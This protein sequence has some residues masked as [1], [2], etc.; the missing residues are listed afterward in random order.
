MIHVLL[1][2]KQEYALDVAHTVELFHGRGTY[3]NGSIDWDKPAITLENV[4]K[5]TLQSHALIAAVDGQPC[6]LSRSIKTDC[7]VDFFDAS[8]A[9]G[10]AAIFQTGI[11][12]LGYGFHLSEKNLHPVKGGMDGD[13]IYYDFSN[14]LSEITPDIIKAATIRMRS[15]L[16]NHYTVKPGILPFHQVCRELTSAGN[17]ALIQE[18]ESR[19]DGGPVAVYMMNDYW[20]LDHGLLLYH[21]SIISSISVASIEPISSGVR[22]YGKIELLN[23]Q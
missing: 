4:A 11:F 18:I 22:V 8:S 20:E 6:H 9:P 7:S 17:V 12:L 14:A 5:Q 3:G 16:A 10:K 1:N 15:A 23:T 13:L 19:D 21:L 2:K